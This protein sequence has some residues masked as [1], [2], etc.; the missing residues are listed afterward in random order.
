MLLTVKESFKE[1]I[2]LMSHIK[3]FKT[4][5]DGNL[6]FGSSNNFQVLTLIFDKGK[7][8]RIIQELIKTFAEED[9]K[10]FYGTKE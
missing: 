7:D 1:V 3:M 8:Q 2:V 10:E 5:I 4:I 6:R 9:K